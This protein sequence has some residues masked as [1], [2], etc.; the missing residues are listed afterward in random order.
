MKSMKKVKR[1][2]RLNS[3]LTVLLSFAMILGSTVQYGAKEVQAASAATTAKNAYYNFLSKSVYWEDMYCAPS[4]LKFGLVDVDNDKVPELYLYTKK[5]NYYYDYKLYKYLGGKVKCLYSFNR[6]EKLGKVYPAKKVFTSRGTGMKYGSS[7]TTYVQCANGKATPK[8]SDLYSGLTGKHVYSNGAGKSLSKSSY[9]SALKK[10]IGTSKASNAP[11][12][13]NNTVSN[14]KAKLKNI[15]APA[16]AKFKKT[17]LFAFTNGGFYLKISSVS[18]NKMKFSIHMPEAT[19]KNISATID[20]SG[21]KATAKFTC[22][23][24]KTHNLTLEIYGKG[25]KVTEKTSCT[26]KLLGWLPEHKY[27]TSV[28]QVFA[29]K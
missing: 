2:R 14:R 1:F 29:Y 10:L 23:K 13:Y 3:L 5:W 12:L 9:Q 26:S 8:L 18:G 17:T 7:I 25:I 27:Q 19:R 21:S 11:T 22:S 4:E 20:S 24:N 15:T 6:G 16:S 28:T